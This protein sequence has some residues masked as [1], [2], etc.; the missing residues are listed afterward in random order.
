VGRDGSLVGAIQQVGV[1]ARL[2]PRQQTENGG[3]RLLESPVPPHDAVDLSVLPPREGAEDHAMLGERP[4]HPAG[5]LQH[6][7][8]ILVELLAQ[9]PADRAET[10]TAARVE[11]HGVALVVELQE[12]RDFPARARVG[13]LSRQ[14]R[15]AVDLRLRHPADRPRCRHS[16]EHAE[17]T[18]DLLDLVERPMRDE[19]AASLLDDDEA[20]VR[21]LQERLADGG[22]A[23]AVPG[24]DLALENPCARVEA[25][26][27]DLG[28][29]ELV[30][31]VLE[32]QEVE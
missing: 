16:F 17:E 9:A 3:A 25:A 27:D 28:L 32:R 8:R 20:L 29:E 31:L 23:D 26:A 15:E 13:E 24:A 7:E 10:R 11:E 1:K 30:D 18:V 6:P 2:R 22:A 21:E 14:L 4:L 19:D 5:E 12:L